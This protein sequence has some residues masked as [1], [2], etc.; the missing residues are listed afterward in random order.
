M[1]ACNRQNPATCLGKSG[2][3]PDDMSEGDPDLQGLRTG[4]L[5][6][7]LD[8]GCNGPDVY[9]LKQKLDD[10]TQVLRISCTQVTGH[11][12]IQLLLI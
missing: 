4:E 6:Q 10:K 3:I 7:I 1:D 12:K 11:R 8:V 9:F 5:A 2:A